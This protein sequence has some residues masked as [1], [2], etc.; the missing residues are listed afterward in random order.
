MN[1]RQYKLQLE[2][3]R[4]QGIDA[5]KKATVYRIKEL[6]KNRDA[7]KARE[8]VH[9]SSSDST[10]R[11]KIREAERQEKEALNA[12]KAVSRLQSK[13]AGSLKYEAAL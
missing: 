9:K 5:E 1:A 4:K 13:V 8:A 11:M 3:K 2:C 7:L 10:R 12:G 6:T